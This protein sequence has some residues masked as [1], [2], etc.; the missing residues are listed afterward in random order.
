MRA[1]ADITL[2]TASLKEI[3]DVLDD[4]NSIAHV[5]RQQIT[6]MKL[7][8]D[9][10]DIQRRNETRR[11]LHALSPP[12]KAYDSKGSKRKRPGWPNGHWE[13]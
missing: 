2:E 1:M 3:K 5:F 9:D 8:V 12:S 10:I 4:L 7:M 13:Q 6:V 11:K